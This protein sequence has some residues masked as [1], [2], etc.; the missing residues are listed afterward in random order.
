M[1]R[2][3][4]HLWMGFE[5]GKKQ[6]KVVRLLE[7]ELCTECRFGHKAE[8]EMTDGSIQQMIHCRRLDCDNWDYQTVDQAADI[9]ESGFDEADDAA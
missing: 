8:V 5:M 3:E 9:L 7:P 6:L 1:L 2:R 4:Q